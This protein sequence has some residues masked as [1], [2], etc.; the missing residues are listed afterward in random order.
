[1][2]EVIS[3]HRRF[4]RIRNKAV[5]S[6]KD[7]VNECSDMQTVAPGHIRGFTLIELMVTVAVLAIIIGVA[8]PS[9][10]DMVRNN[11]SLAFGDEFITTMNY[12]RS[13][14][15][16]RA[17]IVSICAS[18]VARDDC[19]SDWSNGWLVFH[20]QDAGGELGTT[21]TISADS[22]IL[23]VREPLGDGLSLEV[24]RG[25]TAVTYVR[26][27]SLGALART[28]NNTV[29]VVAKHESCTGDATRTVRVSL[30]GSVHSQR[31]GC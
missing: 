24:S 21:P 25:G 3:V 4:R 17:D 15:V 16:K 7:T 11:R 19:G 30:S 18:N 10:T 2:V 6:Y 5:S 1:M 23:R 14:A 9:F 22:D 20:D 28:S 13:E 27:N 31:T 8:I 12:A 29:T 26:F